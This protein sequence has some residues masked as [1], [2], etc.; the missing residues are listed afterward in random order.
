M[1]GGCSLTPA[2]PAERPPALTLARVCAGYGPRPVLRGLDLTIRAGEAYA[3]LGPNGAGKSTAA[4]VACGLMAP[5]AG[6]V[7]IGGQDPNRGGGRRLAGLAPQEIALFPALTIRENLVIMGRLAGLDRSDRESGVSR[8][9]A[10]TDCAAR[11]D[12]TVATLSGGWRRRANLAAALVNRPALLVMDEPT[13]GVDATTRATLAK[14]VRQALRDGAGCLIVSH[15]APF[16][17]MA[18]DRIG[19]LSEGRLVAEGE[20][21]DLLAETFGPG[22]LLA[23]RF[24]APPSATLADRLRGAGLVATDSD[25]TWRVI[26]DDVLAIAERIAGDVDEGGGELSIRRPG[27]DDLVAR[28]LERK[29]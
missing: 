21:R 11:A 1:F 20:R 27:L 8:A 6:R 16:V 24:V 29:T 4:R 2:L 10:L 3:L 17:E 18:A 25:L 7:D 9:L 19:V 28:L 14:A 23:A 5:R 13:E 22:R 15:D 12:Q 26:G